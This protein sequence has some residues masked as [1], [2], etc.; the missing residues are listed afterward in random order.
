MSSSPLSAGH[1]ASELWL[2]SSCGAFVFGSLL[3]ACD[4]GPQAC[5][6]VAEHG[7]AWLGICSGFDDDDEADELGKICRTDPDLWTAYGFL[8]YRIGT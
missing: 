8:E 2:C 7:S 5:S 4:C 6:I 1:E 3:R